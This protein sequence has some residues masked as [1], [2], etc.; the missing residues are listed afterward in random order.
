MYGVRSSYGAGM[1]VTQIELDLQVVESYIQPVSN[2]NNNFS[3]RLLYM[4]A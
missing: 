4:F 3:I 1:T 2:E